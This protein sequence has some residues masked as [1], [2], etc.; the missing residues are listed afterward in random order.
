MVAVVGLLVFGLASKGSSGVALGEV[1]PSPALP[2]LDGGGTGS[3]AEYKGGW[4]LVNVWASWCIP[5]TQE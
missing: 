2:R 5:C 3:L 4:V 1:A